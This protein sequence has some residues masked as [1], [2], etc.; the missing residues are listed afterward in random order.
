MKKYQHLVFLLLISGIFLMPLKAFLNIHQSKPVEISLQNKINPCPNQP[1]TTT[2]CSSTIYWFQ[3]ESE[4]S[5][6]EIGM[7]IA[8]ILSF[9]LLC[10]TYLAP[11]GTIFKPPALF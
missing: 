3:A 8:G 4:L 6:H 9:F 5:L 1:G 2:S 7:V 11:Q 10:S